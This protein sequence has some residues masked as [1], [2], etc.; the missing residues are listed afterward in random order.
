MK[1]IDNKEQELQSIIDHQT[2]LEEEVYRGLS[3]LLKNAMPPHSFEEHFS[4]ISKQIRHLDSEFKVND[5]V[6]TRAGN[7]G[8]VKSIKGDKPNQTIKVSVM[9]SGCINTLG[10]KDVLHLFSGE[11]FAEEN[12]DGLPF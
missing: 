10:S 4:T 5:E 9:G 3:F 7:I 8:Y 2:S 1:D 11:K 12:T 6:K